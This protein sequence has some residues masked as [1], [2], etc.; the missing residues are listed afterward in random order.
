MV[1]AGL[2]VLTVWPVV[3]LGLVWRYD[4]NPWKLAGWGMYS[5]PQLPG[6]V[7][8]FCLTPDVVGRYELR[9]IQPD[10]QPALRAFQ[11]SRLGLGR[12]AGPDGFARALLD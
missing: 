11:R 10:L 2:I 3:H 7:Q 1:H 4:V 6:E 8:V 9:T 5:A 12:L